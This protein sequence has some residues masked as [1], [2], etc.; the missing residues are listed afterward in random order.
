MKNIIKKLF[1]FGM[2][3]ALLCSV[4]P[5]LSGVMVS[6]DASVKFAYSVKEDGTIKITGAESGASGNL[7]IPAIIDGYTV[8]EIGSY[9]FGSNYNITSVVIENG[10]KILGMQAFAY[11]E[12]LADVSVPDSVEII[13]AYAFDGT[14]WYDNQPDGIIYAGRVVYKCKGDSPENIVLRDGT[15]SLSDGAFQDCENLKSITMPDSVTYIGDFAFSNCENLSDVHLS[16]NITTIDWRAF[17][18]CKNFKNIDL[19]EKLEKIGGYAFEEC[20]ITCANISKTVT[21]IDETSFYNCENLAEINVDINNEYYSSLNGVLY[22]KEKTTLIQCPAKYSGELT[23]PESVN[24]M[25]RWAFDSCSELTVVNIPKNVNNITV[26]SLKLVAVNVDNNNPNFSS[27]DG[28]LY[29]KDKTSLLFCPSKKTGSLEIP[30][31]VTN[32]ASLSNCSE[33]ININVASANA[34]YSS[35]SGV[36]FNKEKTKLICC[37]R[38]KAGQYTIPNGVIEIGSSAFYGCNK[39]TGIVMPVSVTTMDYNAFRDCTGLKKVT[40]SKKLTGIDSYCFY[41]CSSIESIDIPDSVEF[42]CESSFNYCT[43]LKSINFGEGVSSIHFD[44]GIIS[45]FYGCINLEQITVSANNQV[46]SSVDGVLYNKNQT[47]LIYCPEGKSSLEYMPD[48]VTTFAE[49]AFYENKK[50]ESVNL[51][52]NLDRIRVYAF[53]NN[54]NL[55]K[56]SDLCSVTSISYGAFQNCTSL[57]SITLPKKIESISWNTFDN[58]GSLKNVY[59]EGTEDE[60]GQVRIDSY[61][62]DALLNATIH[63]NTSIHRHSYIP[64]ITKTTLKANGKIVNKCSCGAAKTTTIYYPK[65]IKLSATEYTYDGKAKNPAVTVIDSSGKKISTTNY[66]ITYKNNI[67]A[68][69]ATAIVTFKG[70]Y[71]GTKS[72][73]YKINSISTI[74]AT[75]KLSTTSYTY[76]GK[77]KTPIATVKLSGKTLKKNTDYTVKYSN[78]IKAGTA[79]ATITFKGNY[80]GTKKVTYK[81]NTASTTKATYKLSTTSYTYSGKAKTPTVTVK[82]SGK[83]LKKNT[84]YTVQY[85]NNKSVGKATVKVTFKGNYSGTKTL[86]FKINP[87]K[88]TVKSLTAGK[89]SL[90]VAITKKTTQV[91]GYQI[92]YATNKSFKSAKTKYVTSYKTTSVTL[93][94]LSAKKTYYVRVRTY[95]T[96]KGVKYYSGWS[97]VKYK[98]TK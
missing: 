14:A 44:G 78:N 31:T 7:T 55:K 82:L 57:E 24:D 49:G 8:T 23:M 87:V 72:L 13:D 94:G 33:L 96:V 52:E 3:I 43:S 25:N 37:P 36:L 53:R 11:C 73:T 38:N 98:K 39:L 22:N 91:T 81:I 71:T 46:Y 28:V 45:Y 59:Y 97:T 70:N 35:I 51:S 61:G 56:I 63:Y 80:S 77:A 58:C 65:T 48:T 19:P 54:S 89:K 64:T 20:G 86:T 21:S 29:N 69:T 90:K 74:K 2:C 1:C 30:K 26:D 76:D 6:A 88:T 79:T 18:S 27:I 41:G 34:N 75:V 9:A 85:S 40:L 32:I 68:G 60:W 47:E 83:T 17:D 12:Y 67:N 84:D 62:N 93:K 4:C 15:A 92:Q 5:I 10:V 95:K 66:S 42:I 16:D 50:L